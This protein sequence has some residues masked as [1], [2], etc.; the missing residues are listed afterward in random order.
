MSIGQVWSKI[1]LLAIGVGLL[2]HITGGPL[3]A[4]VT[5]AMV[6]FFLF[7]ILHILYRMSD[8]LERVGRILAHDR[9][10]SEDDG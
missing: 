4:C 7:L 1:F 3:W 6:F 2:I 10:E 9:D 8:D 5:V